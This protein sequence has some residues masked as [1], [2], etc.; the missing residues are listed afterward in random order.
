MVSLEKYLSD[1]DFDSIALPDDKLDECKYF[2]HLLTSENDRDKFRWLLSAFL[3]AC[4]SFLEIKAKSL[5]FA[6]NDPDTGE[7]IEDEESL[8]IF[9]QYARAFQDKKNPEFVK[10]KGLHDL[11][12]KLYEIRKGNTHNYALSII[13]GEKPSPENFK[14]GHEKSKAVPALE[15]CRQVLFLFEEINEQL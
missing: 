3:N 12:K 15:F 10:T 11:I 7:P 13:K 2:Y 5:Y 4:Y 6:F 14:I 8:K 1:I 9:R